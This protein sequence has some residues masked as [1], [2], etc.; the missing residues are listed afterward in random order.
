[1]KSDITKSLRLTCLLSLILTTAALTTQAQDVKLRLDNLNKL[2]SKASK[3]VDVSLDGQ[4]LRIAIAFL[5][6]KDPKQAEIRDLV[7]GLKGIYVKA[8]E[9]DK[10][11]QYA[12]A[13]VDSLYTQLRSPGWTRMVGVKSNK[14]N[15]SAEVYM[16]M[17]GNQINGI[18]VIAA[19]K[20]EL[21]VINIV[22][23]ID[24]D[25]LSRL[26]GKFGI[27]S[28]DINLGNKEPKE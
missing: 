3:S 25:K 2:E 8:F 14:E 13:D 6:P 18:T 24:L 5:N 27:P 15:Q 19:D 17:S 4:L 11:G 1:M 9:F 12:V 16:M 20:K 7:S 28:L 22:G 21:A 10:E 23:S 26:S